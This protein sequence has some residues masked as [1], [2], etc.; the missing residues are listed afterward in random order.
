MTCLLTFNSQVTL[1]NFIW[2][3]LHWCLSTWFWF[4]FESTRFCNIVNKSRINDLLVI[5]IN[6]LIFNLKEKPGRKATDSYLLKQT[7]LDTSYNQGLPRLTFWQFL[8]SQSCSGPS[9]VRSKGPGWC[10]SDQPRI[11]F[12]CIYPWFHIL[13]YFWFKR[14]E[15]SIVWQ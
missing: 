15:L 4:H 2:K 8:P 12:T 11:T 6:V 9:K 1:S 7:N 5:L 14:Q 13:V 3:H 10:I